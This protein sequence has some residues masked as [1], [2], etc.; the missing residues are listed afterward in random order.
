MHD[1]IDP[2]LLP[3][4]YKY[5]KVKRIAFSKPRQIGFTETKLAAFQWLMK[6]H[7]EKGSQ[8]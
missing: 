1:R 8:T 6:Y 2:R 5:E 3:L 4:P 7:T